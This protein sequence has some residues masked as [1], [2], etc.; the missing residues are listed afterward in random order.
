MPTNSL[1]AAITGSQSLEDISVL[2]QSHPEIKLD[3]AD[4]NSK[5]A[6]ALAYEKNNI[7]VGLF[8]LRLNVSLA[9]AFNPTRMNLVQ[10]I[11][12][13]K[14]LD[15]CVDLLANNTSE[16]SSAPEHIRRRKE[17]FRLCEYLGDWL[18][19]HNIDN[20][21]YLGVINWYSNMEMPRLTSEQKQRFIRKQLKIFQKCSW[22]ALFCFN[23]PFF[24]DLLNGVIA[25]DDAKGKA[26]I[27]NE[28]NLNKKE[29]PEEKFNEIKGRLGR[30]D[31]AQL[32]RGVAATSTAASSTVAPSSVVPSGSAVGISEINARLEAS[33]E[34]D[35]S[36]VNEGADSDVEEQRHIKRPKLNS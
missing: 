4:D 5:T 31:E 19:S 34:K 21:F 28:L 6:L 14:F 12:L 29:I 36:P 20:S 27:W 25:T 22:D 17:I 15:K 26:I 13:V 7:D 23:T 2:L 1:H 18:F 3:E 30:A 35:S 8:L 10:K 24:D 16:V 9:A 33:E 11:R 32:V